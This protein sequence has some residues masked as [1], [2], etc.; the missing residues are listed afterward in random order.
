MHQSFVF[1]LQVIALEWKR[2]PGSKPTVVSFRIYLA[3]VLRV[4]LLGSNYTPSYSCDAVTLI[5]LWDQAQQRLP[6]SENY[7]MFNTIS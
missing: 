1:F 5:V 4:I 6:A 7:W 3:Y 2:E